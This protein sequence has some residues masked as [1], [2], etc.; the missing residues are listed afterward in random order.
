M[1][2]KTIEMKITIDESVCLKHKMTLSECLLA[3]ALRSAKEND[4]H[5][6]LNREILV[7]KSGH[8]LV[9]QHWSDELDEILAESSSTIEKTDEEL[10]ALAQKMRELYPQGRM[11]DMRTGKPTAYYF[12]CNNSEVIKKLKT[13]FARY[14]NYSDENI[15]DAT[16]R[17]VA[18]FRG[19]YQQRGFRI[20]KYFIFKDDVKQG[21]DGNYVESLSPLLD[22]LDNKESEQEEDNTSD[23]WLMNV[24]N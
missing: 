12:R 18:S 3:L 23:D 1:N 5:N 20:I 8:Y 24:R 19:N 22:F 9:T 6:M 14:G 7:R 21:P 17:Y 11:I 13:F 4:I 15:L 10:L 2:L 16:R